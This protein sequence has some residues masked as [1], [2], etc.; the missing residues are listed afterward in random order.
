MALSASIT[1]ASFGLQGIVMCFNADDI[2]ID[3]DSIVRIMRRAEP[4]FDLLLPLIEVNAAD[5]RSEL[6]DKGI[7]YISCMVSQHCGTCPK[8]VRG[9]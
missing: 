4:A 6:K 5:I 8:C 7:P 1:A 2:G 9:Y 3:T